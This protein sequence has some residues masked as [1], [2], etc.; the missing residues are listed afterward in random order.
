MTGVVRTI[1]RYCGHEEYS[2]ADIRLFCPWCKER[3]HLYRMQALSDSERLR[4]V[5]KDCEPE[6]RRIA[7]AEDQ[8]RDRS[9][10]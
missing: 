4:A 8:L 10:D 6:L 1:C 2:L 3:G 7:L 9:K 5:W